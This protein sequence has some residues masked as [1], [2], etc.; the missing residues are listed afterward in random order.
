MKTIRMNPIGRIL[1]VLGIA[2]TLFSGCIKSD[3]EGC[4]TGIELQFRYAAAGTFTRSNP[5]MLDYL[6][7]Y[8]F[9]ADGGFLEQHEFTDIPLDGSYTVTLPSLDADTYRVVAWAG[10]NE[11][12]DLY[13]ITPGTAQQNHLDELRLKLTR[14][15][16]D[17]VTRQPPLLYNGYETVARKPE[18]ARHTVWLYQMTSRIAV[19]AAGVESP[20][21]YAIRIDDNNGTYRFD[22]SFA[23]DE[24]FSYTPAEGLT[25]GDSELRQDF[26]VMRLAESRTPQL[27]ITNPQTGHVLFE[28]NLI[29]ELL[30][31]NPEIDFEYDHDFSIEIRFRDLTPVSITVNGWEVLDEEGELG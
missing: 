3:L 8:I 12:R 4:P 25:L 10:Q 11:N 29:G 24:P 2:A 20:E 7:L 9:D 6:T 1:L 14:P 19:T 16:D 21:H 28:A 31:L 17:R 13:Q 22:R 27:V 5:A 30:G 15:S 23:P 26:T 18:T